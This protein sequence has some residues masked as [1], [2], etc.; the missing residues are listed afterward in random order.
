VPPTTTPQAKR[1]RRTQAERRAAT[2][3]AVLDAA[4]ACL[5]EHGYANTTTTRIAQRAGVSR[6][7]QL[8]HFPTKAS[9]VAQAVSHVARRR[10]DLVRAQASAQKQ[11][12]VEELVD[13]LWELHVSPLFDA[14][15]ELWVAARTDPELRSELLRVE[16]EAS[17]VLWAMCQEVAGE[18][19]RRPGFRADL[20]TA[21]ATMR[22][23][24]LLRIASGP[25]SRAFE[26]RWAV[27][28]T[29]LVDFLA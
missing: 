4:I 24:A 12:G 22:G 21:L 28:R 6:G 9:L 15:L 2:Q 27:A 17:Q 16:R 23:V 26:R 7:A 10:A 18:A 11:L 5:V 20:D 25:G 29:R 1:G 14:S 19:A 8:H 3:E 13:A